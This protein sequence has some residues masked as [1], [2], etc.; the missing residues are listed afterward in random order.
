MTG[1]IEC[2]F[3]PRPDAEFVERGSQVVLHHLLAGSE[4]AGNIPV[5][6]TLPNQGRDLDLFRS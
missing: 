4:C 6:K 5:G 3:E 2:Q 1:N